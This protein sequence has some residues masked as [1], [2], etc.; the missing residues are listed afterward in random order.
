MPFTC[1]SSSWLT[2]SYLV[3]VAKLNS[4]FFGH[5]QLSGA[6]WIYFTFR[7]FAL[8][9]S[10]GSHVTPLLHTFLFLWVQDYC[11]RLWAIIGGRRP[12]RPTSALCFIQVAVSLGCESASA[13]CCLRDP[14]HNTLHFI[15]IQG[16]CFTGERREKWHTCETENGCIAKYARSLGRPF[17]I[18]GARRVTRS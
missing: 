4:L 1:L 17:K 10:S 5:C 16:L 9:P 6:Y 2:I 12:S 18:P 14:L 13:N 8:L 3:T 7:E 11:L 15:R